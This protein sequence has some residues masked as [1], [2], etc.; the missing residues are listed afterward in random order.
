MRMLMTVM[1]PHLEFNAA[2]KAG[3][4]EKKM[5]QIMEALKP[6]AAYFTCIAGH[7]AALLVID[8][9]D[10][11]Q[12]PA[13]AEPWFLGFNADVDFNPVMTADDLKQ[14]GLEALGNKWA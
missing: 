3:T 7:R 12:I 8:V 10:P 2:L 14:A 4:V 11:S 13:V 9:A 1:L 5:G 6:E